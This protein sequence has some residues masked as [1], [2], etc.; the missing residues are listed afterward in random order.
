[1]LQRDGLPLLTKED[2]FVHCHHRKSQHL[3]STWICRSSH[4]PI[5]REV[6]HIEHA[7]QPYLVTKKVQSLRGIKKR[8]KYDL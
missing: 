5:Q 6:T 8:I 2:I 4:T 3:A 1:M 7:P